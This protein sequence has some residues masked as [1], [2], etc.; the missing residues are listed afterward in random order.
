IKKSQPSPT[1]GLW[2]KVETIDLTE[3]AGRLR[4]QGFPPRTIRAIIAAQIRE[5]FAGQ[6]KA[7]EGETTDRPFWEPYARDPKTQLALNALY[8]EQEKQLRA[9]LGREGEDEGTRA[10]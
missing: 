1:D 6:R 8:R 4:E 10:S 9:V 3:L 2:N 5:N 7:L